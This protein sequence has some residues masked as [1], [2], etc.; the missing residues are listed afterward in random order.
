MKV[1][2]KQKPLGYCQFKSEFERKKNLIRYL[3]QNSP[4]K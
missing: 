4:F 1:K 3:L 2:T